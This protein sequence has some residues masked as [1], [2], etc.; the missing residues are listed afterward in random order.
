MSRNNT[1]IDSF[2]TIKELIAFSAKKYGDDPSII[3]YDDN[4]IV[5]KSYNDLYNDIT[6]RGNYLYKN[7]YQNKK[8]S[9][10]GNL[11]YDWIVNFYSIIFAK[12]IPVLIDNE[13]SFEDISELMSKVNVDAV[14]IDDIKKQNLLMGIL[15]KN[16]SF[17]EL[18]SNTK[19]IDDDDLDFL[20]IKSS[21]DD[22]AVIV[23][24]SG[25][26][27]SNKAVLL[28]N[29]NLCSNLFLS[30]S[31]IKDSISKSAYSSTVA[32][33]PPHH[34]FQITAGINM[35][36][37]IG[38]PICI[39]RGRK[40]IAQDI[41]R[42]KPTT[43]TLVPAA[44]EMIRKR[45]WLKAKNNNQEKTLKRAMNISNFLL[46]FKI[47][48]RK[49]IFSKLTNSLGGNLEKII[50]G[51]APLDNHI[52]EDFRAWGIEIYNGY[53]ITECSPV[54]SCNSKKYY[55]KNSVGKIIKNPYYDVKIVDDEILVKGDIVM[56]GYYKDNE[57]TSKVMENGW[58]KTGDLGYIDKDN[59]LYISGRKK[60]IILLENGEN[61]CPEELE[62]IYSRIGGVKDLL[63]Y[64]E[65]SKNTKIIKCVVVPTKE[66][67][68][69]NIEL[70]PYFEKEFDIINSK[71]P[72]YKQVYD[73]SIRY[74]DFIKSSNLKIKRIKENYAS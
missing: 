39:G 5:V 69:N 20:K 66:L 16:V 32:I 35:P 18:S 22:G 45:I 25:T 70:R 28:S 58:F 44:I 52:A 65:Q 62:L 8:I 11:N 37:H 43:L 21:P 33:L 31:F 24:T 57:S 42:F 13:L 64:S 10:I 48:A 41:E 47:D 12:S 59:Y 40:Y 50:S 1:N 7:N 3:Y 74:L 6:K 61:I 30:H 2:M 29:R 17:L 55:R 53:G 49:F 4:S 60:N 15:N 27:G 63:I 72:Y 19:D 46:K 56:K 14:V 38:A 71:L 26:T 51:G 67:I 9:L 36:I 68:E 34:M 73:I 54:V 23:F